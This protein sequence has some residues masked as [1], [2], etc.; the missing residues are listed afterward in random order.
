M[1][2]Q[3]LVTGALLIATLLALAWF[4][5]LVG[6]QYFW[7]ARIGPGLVFAAFLLIV[8]APVIANEMATLCN[9]GSGFLARVV[10]FVA[11]VAGAATLFVL[12][13]AV[14]EH[15]RIPIVCTTIA[16][17]AVLAALAHAQG[18]NSQNAM[19]SIG[20]AVLTF[21]WIGVPIGF[22]LLLR[23]DREAWTMA[24][25]ILCVKS[26]DIGAYFTGMAIGRHKLIPWLSPGKSWEGFYGG[27][28][29]SAAVGALL[30][31][32]S[33]SDWAADQLVEPI[34]VGF[35]A[36]AGAFLGIAGVV[37]DLFESLLKRSSGAK[38]S[39]NALPGMGGA[40]DVLDSLLP[41]GPLAW[42]L[43][44]S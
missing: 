2:R 14:T 44:A 20:G 34:G 21:A 4:D 29:T 11:I 43:L 41:A 38:D 12:T 17:I 7:G 10:H 26:S 19:A 31:Y 30:A 18:R 36:M 9:L 5:S 27:L 16:G 39:G 37:G 32:G 15:H 1:L 24:A 6:A 3:R 8:V 23:R 28:A 42:W 25:A 33:Q 22:W 35:G 40:F 13:S